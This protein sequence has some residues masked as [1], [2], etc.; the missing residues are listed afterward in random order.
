MNN[1]RAA[2]TATR[3]TDRQVEYNFRSNC[4]RFDLGHTIYVNVRTLYYDRMHF[5]SKESREMEMQFIIIV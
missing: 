5:Y 1:V 2:A 4:I 3:Q